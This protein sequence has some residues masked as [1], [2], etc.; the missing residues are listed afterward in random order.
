[1][2]QHN[3][4]YSTVE[5]IYDLYLRYPHISTDSRNIKQGDVFFA[6]RGE[7]FDG[8]NFA[9]KA[10][11]QGAAAVVSDSVQVFEKYQ[12][13]ERRVSETERRSGETKRRGIFFFCRDSL[14]MLQELAKYHR[15][16]LK[17]TIIG[18][19]GTN[20][21]TTTKELI[22]S[23][24]S[25]AFK[26]RATAG[27]LNNHIGV[28]LTLLSITAD[29][30]VAIVEMGANHPGEI[31][32]L[33]SIARPDMGILTNIGTAHIEGF[34]S[35]ENIIT[36][37]KALFESVKNSHSS[38]AH[39]FVNQ[40]DEALKDY[41]FEAKT[42]YSLVNPSD[43]KGR[44][45][46]CSGYASLW[47]EDTE[48]QSSLVGSYNCY[49][50]LAAYVIGRH[51]GI[52]K[53]QIRK[54]IEQ[55]KPANQRSQILK[56]RSN[57]LI[58]DCYNANPSSCRSA[59]EAFANMKAERKMVFMGAMRELGEVS[60][61]EH[62]NCVEFLAGKDFEQV[63]LV[64]KEYRGLQREKMRWFET[65]QELADTL[66]AEPKIE[67]CTILIKGSRTTRMEIVQDVL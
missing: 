9:L 38:K 13:T 34:K 56:T 7:N 22:Y 43:Y 52:A 27:N 45:I 49:N 58:L 17:T 57:T 46:D 20:G 15:N 42:T 37:K 64:G 1:M 41:D 16:R 36:T 60:E 31:A 63:I 33:C 12:E 53:D 2:E 32:F 21:K 23:V 24:L 40:D 54:S 66:S 28:P 29:T 25:S 67:G 30:E 3:Q 44:S 18:I 50:M 55:Y 6:L 59:I 5:Q 8:N 65:S 26:T 51:F 14:Q 62:K 39:L 4:N 10:L 35:R 19:S 47:I 48:I 11:D 61:Q